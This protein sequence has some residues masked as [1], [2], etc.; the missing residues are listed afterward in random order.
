MLGCESATHTFIHTCWWGRSGVSKWAAD[1]CTL[2]QLTSW[3]LQSLIQLHVFAG[4]SR[5]VSSPRRLA[6]G[7]LWILC[8]P[9]AWRPCPFLV[10]AL[11]DCRLSVVAPLYWPIGCEIILMLGGGGCCQ[12]AALNIE[13]SPFSPP[14]FWV[15]FGPNYDYCIFKCASFDQI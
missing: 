3:P 10:M 11:R 12:G 6:L 13:E 9:L 5:H 14:F 8:A 1:M 7:S 2:S 4:G 15:L